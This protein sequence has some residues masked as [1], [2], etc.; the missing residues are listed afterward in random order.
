MY[1]TSK[2]FCSAAPSNP[3]SVDKPGIQIASN[4]LFWDKDRLNF[5]P[6]NPLFLDKKWPKL[7]GA[8]LG[9]RIFLAQILGIFKPCLVNFIA[10]MCDPG[11][12]AVQR[13]KELMGMIG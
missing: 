5:G 12:G 8:C 7:P 13:E 9:V 6:S 4:P 1:G 3:L 2:K 11:F 10:R